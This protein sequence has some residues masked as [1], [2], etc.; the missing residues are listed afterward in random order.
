MRTSAALFFGVL[1]LMPI[2]WKEHHETDVGN[3]MG[4]FCIP[5]K[6]SPKGLSSVYL[7]CKI[8]SNSQAAE[9]NSHL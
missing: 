7:N 3:L 6:T 9:G 5:R 8:K 2:A 1:E 4:S